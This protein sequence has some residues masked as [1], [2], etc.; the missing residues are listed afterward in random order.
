MMS[1][2]GLQGALARIR[3]I[4]S[5][6]EPLS[7]EASDGTSAGGAF[8]DALSAA[9]AP[10]GGTD[11]EAAGSLSG[12]SSLSN[13]AMPANL[14]EVI[15]EQGE[16][17]QLDPNLLK[18]VIRNESNFNPRAVSPVGA[19]GLMQLMPGTA[20]GL[21]VQDSFDPAQNVAGGAKYLKSLLNRYD[22]SLPL[23]LAAYNAGPGAVDKHGGVPPYAET[24]RYV[25]KV[26]QSY[27]AYQSESSSSASL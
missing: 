18:A 20:R 22:Q 15:R 3:E 11:A 7:S 27:Q 4:Q 8:A 17:A 10:G 24:T 14:T 19:Q 9:M 2:E 16:R 13:L 1:L 26:M 12:L 6:L 21:G 23:A 25:Q 5:R